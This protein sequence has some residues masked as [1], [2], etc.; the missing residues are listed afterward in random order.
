VSAAAGSLNHL[1]L[2]VRDPAASAVLYGP[3]LAELGWT[4]TPRDDGGCAWERR[5]SDAGTHWLI[6]T[7]V[8]EAHREAPLHDDFAP[9]IHHLTLNAADRAQVHRVH[10]ILLDLRTEIID[11]PGIHN[12]DPGYYAIFFRDPD[13]FKLEVVHLS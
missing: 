9:G 8:A 6:L 1:R 13:G 7:P 5:S 11:P 3:V 2:S 10:D 4:E 12:G